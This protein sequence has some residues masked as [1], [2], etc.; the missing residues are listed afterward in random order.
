VWVLFVLASVTAWV[1]L[2]TRLREGEP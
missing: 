1:A 2:F